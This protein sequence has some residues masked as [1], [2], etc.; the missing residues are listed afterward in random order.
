MMTTYECLNLRPDG[1][2]LFVEIDAPP[3]NAIGPELVRD[4]VTLIKNIDEG[5]P[6]RVIFFSSANPDFFVSHV[7][8]TRIKEYRQAAAKLTGEASIA[9][10][11]RRLSE[12]KAI[13]INQIE[14][15]VRGAGSEFVLACDMSFAALETALFCQMGRKRALEVVLNADDYSAKIAE[16]YGW[17]NRAVPAAELQEFV[18]SL[19]KRIATFPLSGL[20]VNKQ[21]VNEITLANAEAFRADSDLFG[22]NVVGA[23]EQARLKAALDRGFGKAGETELNLG[24]ELGKL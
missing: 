22:N 10:L 1:A 2:V 5:D 24:R 3:I 19:A 23:T 18:S 6:Y 16:Q 14:G 4:L 15:R 17:I 9:M 20:I 21:R 7:D 12:T 11:F 13:T 8:V